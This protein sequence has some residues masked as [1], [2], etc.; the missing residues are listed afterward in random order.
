MIDE[1]VYDCEA[2]FIIPPGETLLETIEEL[3]I[4]QVELAKRTGR[5]VKTINEIIKG[6]TKI[7]PDT[8]L[9]FE[10]VL[11]VPASLWNNLEKDYRELLAKEEDKKNLKNS[12]DFLDEFPIKEMIRNG[13]IKHKENDFNQVEELFEFFGVASVTSW[14]SF[15][16]PQVSFRKSTALKA[17]KYAVIAYL[18]KAEIEAHKIDCSPYKSG[19]FRKIIEQIRGLTKEKNP[20]IFIPKIV[21]SCASAGVAVVFL[22]ELKGTRLSGATKW[23]NKDKAMI[24]LSARHKTN[25][26]LWFTFFHEAGHVLLHNKKSTFVEGNANYEDDENEQE[27]NKFSADI[28]IPEDK[29]DK[30]TNSNT[31]LSAEKVTKFADQIGIHPGI[32]VGRLQR[33]KILPYS[34]LNKLKERYEWKK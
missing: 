30:F 8:A 24:V 1:K 23:L 15:W 9:Q 19:D 14:E 11:G 33:D 17:D 28:L 13:W 5:P 32:V 7:T 10:R 31:T 18:R 16:E 22:P 27:A 29:Y 4:T 3:D 2:D 12:V 26:H 21:E 25:D 34:H 6:K 20:D